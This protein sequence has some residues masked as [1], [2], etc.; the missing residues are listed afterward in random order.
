MIESSHSLH[1]RLPE[2]RK[3]LR[4]FFQHQANWSFTENMALTKEI[5]EILV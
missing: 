3:L 2:F 1:Q 4:E 5:G